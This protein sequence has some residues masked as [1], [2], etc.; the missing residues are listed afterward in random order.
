MIVTMP[1][2]KF[3]FMLRAGAVAAG[4]VRAAFLASLILSL[5]AVLNHPVL[6][7]DGM[8]YV[9]IADTLAGHGP[10]DLRGGYL[11]SLSFLPSLM[12]LTGVLTGL[13]HEAAAHFLNALF[14]AGTCSLLVAIVRRHSPE[15]AW[16]ACLVVLAMPAFN[17]YR[18]QV[19][20][21][22]GFWFFSMLALWLAT[23]RETA[24]ISW[25]AALACQMSIVCAALFRL[26][27]LAYFLALLLWQASEAPPGKRLSSMFK[28]SYLAVGGGVAAGLLFASGFV[29]LPE[30]LA[31][32]IDAANPMRTLQIIGEA[33]NR[34]SDLV[35]KYKYSREEAGYVLFFGL[36]SIIPVKFLK[37]SGLLVVPMGYA[38]ASQSLRAAL[39]R[40]GL[41]GWFFITHVLVLVAF[42]THQFFL[43]GRYVAMLNLLAVP[44]AAI[45]FLALTRRFPRWRSL[46]IVLALIMMV[47]NVVSL[48]ARNTQI[49][50]A[51]KW[52]QS[53]RMATTRIYVD[54]PRVAFYAGLGYV[55]AGGS[56]LSRTDL[57]K[58]VAENRFDMIVL[59]GSHKERHE[60]DAWLTA[61]NLHIIKEFSNQVGNAVI[62]A[63]LRG[64]YT[65]P[66]MT[67]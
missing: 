43:V 33:A 13:S 51:G 67:E 55:A 38:F 27:A 66:S 45:G 48:S 62:V 21:E 53:A 1:H 58:A 25:P 49:V 2:Q 56:Q 36:L 59:D 22:Y 47:A 64:T 44:L 5:V 46:M 26:E 52:L 31:Y 11:L 40:S 10:L 63:A 19:L 41:L 57:A 3:F 30:R 16:A 28:V 24:A 32:F 39:T 54:N 42:V 60:L 20:R 29:A 15:A 12:A 34:M 50:E 65:S 9:E 8:L 17:E 23:R 18:N 14:L 61:N 6:N 35:F 4:P 37:M 7:R